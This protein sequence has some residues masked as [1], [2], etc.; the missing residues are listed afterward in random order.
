MKL[1]NN[2]PSFFKIKGGRLK[3]GQ[4]IELGAVIAGVVPLVRSIMRGMEKP[5][6]V[7]DIPQI[8]GLKYQ[9][10]DLC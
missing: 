1:K 5:P 3:N 6:Q 8:K 9:A 2:S 10:D 7:I 4:S